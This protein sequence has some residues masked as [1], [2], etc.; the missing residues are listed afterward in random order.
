MKLNKYNDPGHGWLKVSKK[1][2]KELGIENDISSFS[3][4]RVE[5]AYLEE[6]SDCSIFCEA[7]EKA[8]KAFEIIDSHADNQSKIRQYDSYKIYTPEQLSQ[9]SDLCKRMLGSNRWNKKT[10][11][12]IS[13]ASLVDLKD[14]QEQY[15]F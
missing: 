5:Y 15:N 3:Y 12:K 7:M 1:L 14:W 8:G 11:K 9:M 10:I 2:L 13:I 4:M 6:D